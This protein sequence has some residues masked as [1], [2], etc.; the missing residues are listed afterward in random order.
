MER[1][2]EMDKVKVGVIG[3]GNM[4]Q[5]AHIPCI[6]ANPDAELTAICDFRKKVTA[7][8]C[9]RWNIPFA[10]DSADEL[11][12]QD[13]DAV[14]ILTP[15]QAHLSNIRA[16]LAAGKAV[17][18]EKPVAMSAAGVR[19]LAAL[20]G[21]GVSVGY[22]KQHETNIRKLKEIQKNSDWGKLLFIRN[23]SFV[24]KQWNG[25][26]GDLE[27]VCSSDEKPVFNASGLDP[28]PAWLKGERDEKFYSFDN[29]YYGL[30]DT[31][32]HSVN[33]LRHLAGSVPK[34]LGVN[35]GSGV[36]VVHFDF[37]GTPGE[38]EFCVN[39]RMDRWDEV[40]ELYFERASVRILTPAPLD[41]QSSA[42]VE[43]Y[44]ESGGLHQ[45][46]VLED[47]RK[48]AFRLETDAFIRKVKEGNC[49]SDLDEAADDVAVIEKIYQIEMGV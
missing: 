2:A 8:L 36:R 21:K 40:T 16:A 14:Y 5:L 17:F 18:T 35:S 6:K 44:S 26:L 10:T 30:L 13:L 43:I 48:W 12:K 9:R 33:L 34:V 27:K 24:G 42:V 49:S 20:P 28:A 22:M 45:N 38:M 32:C 31:G 3:C 47:T 25:A 7:E 11:L 41:R 15:Q 29:P 37:N 46:L 19:E 4:A 39:F 1:S 23:H